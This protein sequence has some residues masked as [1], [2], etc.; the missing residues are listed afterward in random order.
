MVISMTCILRK[1]ELQMMILLI[2][3]DIS[4]FLPGFPGGTS[5][6][7]SACQ[8]RRFKRLRFDPWV[9]KILWRRKWHPTLVFCRGNPMDRGYSPLSGKVLDT[10]EHLSTLDF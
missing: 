1:L 5:G 4:D 10:T 2:Y 3:K 9:A 8:C 6:N 7:E